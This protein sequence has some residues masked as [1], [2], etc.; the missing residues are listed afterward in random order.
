M[1]NKYY[2]ICER[3]TKFNISSN[4]LIY[5]VNLF[6]YL[7]I[8]IGTG[9]GKYLHKQALKLPQT[10]HI[11]IDLNTNNLKIKNFPKNITF[12][13]GDI[14]DLAG[15][16]SEIADYIT[17][18]YPWGILLAQ[19][20]KSDELFF[21]ALIKIT[22]KN[23]QLDFLLNKSIYNNKTFL[24]KFNITLDMFN[25]DILLNKLSHMGFS[26]TE[27]RIIQNSKS[28]IHDTRWGKKLKTRE[29]LYVKANKT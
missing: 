22:K 13:E 19:I 8:D 14:F 6:K 7:H 2:R 11:G 16:Y 1:I 18:N 26:V 24:N 20:I 15:V 23:C 3:T 17:V 9:D 12:I 28:K 27:T 4:L 10:F 5:K 29:I 25:E 21:N